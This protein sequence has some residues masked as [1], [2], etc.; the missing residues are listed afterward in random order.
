MP[1][2]VRKAHHKSRRGCVCCKRRHVKCSETRPRCDHCTRLDIECTWPD[3]SDSN[4]APPLSLSRCQSL[5]QSPAAAIPPFSAASPGPSFSA[6][7][8]R[9][10]AQPELSINELKLLHFYLFNTSASMAAPNLQYLWQNVVV[11]LGFRHHFLLRGILAVAAIHKV[12]VIDAEREELLVQSASHL[13][14]GLR[15]FRKCLESPVPATSVPV[16]LMAGLMAVHSLGTAQIHAPLDPIGDICTWMR[17]VRGVKSTI[18]E[19][20]ELL[21]SSEIGTMLRDHPC[22]TADSTSL[23]E[24]DDLRSLVEQTAAPGSTERGIYLEC[25]D[26]LRAVF[27]TDRRLA[28]GNKKSSA[29]ASTWAATAHEG[30]CELLA[31]RQPLALVII[32]FFSTLFSHCSNIWWY[33]NWDTWILNAVR[34]EL[35]IDYVPWLEWPR[36]QI[37][38]MTSTPSAVMT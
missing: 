37:G 6:G 11:E 25:V 9:S 8:V 4:A 18:H 19:N 3:G 7:I 31:Q 35:P 32:A 22:G 30:Y 14:S 10:K 26:Q 24:T 33:R 17:M 16:F 2:M 12:S 28:S 29:L 21:L 1:E 38:S 15:S 20:W 27:I 34:S 5:P 23:V 13:E 36:T